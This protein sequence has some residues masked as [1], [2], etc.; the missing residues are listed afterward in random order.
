MERGDT[1][2]RYVRIRN[3]AK[4]EDRDVT[5]E[6]LQKKKELQAKGKL[7][8][9]KDE[10]IKRKDNTFFQWIDQTFPNHKEK[11]PDMWPPGQN[12]Q[13]KE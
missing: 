10:G 6:V 7:L 11:K 9:N 2:V 1:N 5:Q 4:V 8:D 13:E 12:P 3:F